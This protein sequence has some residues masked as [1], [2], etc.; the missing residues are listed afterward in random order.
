[1]R[2]CIDMTTYERAAKWANPVI[3]WRKVADTLREARQESIVEY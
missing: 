1:M 3:D 2:G